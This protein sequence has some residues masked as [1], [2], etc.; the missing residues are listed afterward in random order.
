MKTKQKEIDKG[1]KLLAK[2]SVF[3]FITV[4]LSK[5]FAYIYRIIVAR[6]FGP[7]VYGIF[8]LALIIFS[9]F[10]V[11]SSLGLKGGILRFFSQY[12]S[13]KE[14][15]KMNF[16]LKYSSTI[17]FFTGILFSILLFYSSEFISLTFFNEPRLI[18]FLKILSFLIH[19]KIFSDFFLSIITAFQH[20]NASSF[21]EQTLSGL[22]NLLFLVFFI[23]LG[24]QTNS[25]IFS[26]VFGF[27]FVF[28]ASLW[29]YRY[30][31]APKLSSQKI[32]EKD[33]L[34]IK[35]DFISYSLPLVFSGIVSFIFSWID[36]FLVGYFLDVTQV[37]FYNAAVPIA[38]LFT[39][40]PTIFVKMFFPIINREY[41]LKNYGVIEEISKQVTKWIFLINFP[42]FLIILLFPETIIGILFGYEYV[43]AKDALRILAIGYFFFSLFLISERLLLTKGKSKII[44][45]DLIFTSFINIFLNI[46]LIPKFGINGAA[47]STSFSWIILSLLWFF[48]TQKFLNIIPFRRKMVTIFFASLLPFF[49][50]LILKNYF[51]MDVISSVFTGIFFL[52]FY[53]LMILTT[54][55]FDKNDFMVLRS[56]KEKLFKNSV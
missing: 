48:Q 53:L 35:S 1:L 36:S 43:V 10:A 51:Q 45:Y 34:K 28:I 14:Y 46:L 39:F 23:M 3:V 25:I 11:F 37:G 16:L 4:F 19:L 6:H 54:K 12:M 15:S 17:L 20:V 2:T 18:I 32:V 38:L 27:V 22:T 7:E 52:L 9:F 56:F 29:Y 41:S 40:M 13:R 49:V 5:I 30:K 8:S 21:I 47:T 33:K 31:I 26:Y 42:F 24:M 55:C 50:V 44:L